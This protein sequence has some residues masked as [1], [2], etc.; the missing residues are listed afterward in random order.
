V[1]RRHLELGLALALLL[2]CGVVFTW[3]ALR[4]WPGAPHECVAQ[5]DCYCEAQR[6]GFIAQPANTWSCLAGIVVGLLIAWH[7]GWRRSLPAATA[8]PSLMAQDPFFPALYALVVTYSGAA[9]AFFHASLT[10][11]GGKL[12]MASM[13]LFIDYW[14]LYNLASV[15]GLARRTFA[16][17]YLVATSLLLVP[18][19]VFGILGMPIFVLLIGAAVASEVLLS[20]PASVRGLGRRRTLRL[21]RRWLWA[22]L[23]VYVPAFAVW[24]V[25][26]AG[27]A[28]CDPHSLLQGHAAW[29]VLTALSPGALYLYFLQREL[30]M[31]GAHSAGTWSPAP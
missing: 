27:H 21:D 3:G 30:P 26:H 17:S 7:A 2:G 20:V 29:H 22:A 28:L 18:R 12:D 10:A 19:V 24:D 8:G 25:S 23:A 16:L 5:G 6:P 9:A 31:D 4:G 15:Y 14:I 13:Y 1:R 11:W